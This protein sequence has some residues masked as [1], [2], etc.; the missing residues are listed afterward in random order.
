MVTLLLLLLYHFSHQ[1]HTELTRQAQIPMLNNS[2]WPEIFFWWLI[3]GDIVAIC[4]LGKIIFMEMLYSHL[5]LC[6]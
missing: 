5:Y 1:I 4:I 2:C 6:K 3:F